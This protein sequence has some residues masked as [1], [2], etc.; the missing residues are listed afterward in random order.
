MQTFKKCF[1][2]KSLF[3]CTFEFP[4]LHIRLHIYDS[5]SGPHLRCIASASCAHPVLHVAGK[6][7]ENSCVHVGV[8]FDLHGKE[9][10]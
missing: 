1:L 6:K 8:R 9:T 10:L 7:K 5:I 3:Q 2:D 4:Q